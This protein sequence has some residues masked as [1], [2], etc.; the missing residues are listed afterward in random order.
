MDH[1]LTTLMYDIKGV[2]VP[3]AWF[4]HEH[5]TTKD[6]KHFF[7]KLQELG[8][9]GASAAFGNYELAF[10]AAVTN[11]LQIPYWGNYFYFLNAN[12]HWL[13]TNGGHA[14]ICTTLL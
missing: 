2:G 14:F 12:V 3:L 7:L 13:N 9:I 11:I 8:G 10:K 1:T 6:Y 4:I 5:K